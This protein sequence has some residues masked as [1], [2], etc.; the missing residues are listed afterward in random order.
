MKIAIVLMAVA[1]VVFPGMFR[2]FAKLKRRWT[3]SQIDRVA[4]VGRWAFIGAT[5]LLIGLSA[6][7]DFWL[8]AIG[9]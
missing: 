7:N 9:K 8:H 2:V 1:A 4:A 5:I 3:K 6:A